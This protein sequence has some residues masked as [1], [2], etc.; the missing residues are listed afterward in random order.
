LNTLNSIDLDL[1]IIDTFSLHSIKGFLVLS[2]R[3]MG[4][5]FVFNTTSMSFEFE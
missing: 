1:D 2:S 4:K 5:S 3:E